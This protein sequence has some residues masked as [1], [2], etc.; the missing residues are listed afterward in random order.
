M[1]TE[2]LRS[3]DGEGHCDGHLER[4]RFR[5]RL[6]FWNRLH[7]FTPVSKQGK[8]REFVD[9]NL[10]N[11]LWKSNGSFVFVYLA[12]NSVNHVLVAKVRW[13]EKI[14]RA[15]E[16]EVVVG[17]GWGEVGGGTRGNEAPHN[18][19]NGTKWVGKH[20]DQLTSPTAP[21]L[22]LTQISIKAFLCPGSTPSSPPTPSPLLS[23]E[24]FLWNYN[25]GFG[26]KPNLSFLLLG[27]AEIKQSGSP[28]TSPS[29]VFLRRITVLFFRDFR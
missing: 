2:A 5:D 13:M 1:L 15:V 11:R 18:W 20:G 8:W 9:M 22:P 10:S 17:S 19:V 23:N 4:V 26:G 29:I 6:R 3:D 24:S 25:Q 12:R 14:K 16:T 7:R 28:A 27:L 21:S